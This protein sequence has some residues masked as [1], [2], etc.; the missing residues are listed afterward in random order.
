MRII[1]RGIGQGK[2]TELIQEY[3][4]GDGNKCIVVKNQFAAKTIKKRAQEMGVD[5][6]TV[7]VVDVYSIMDRKPNKYDALY[8]DNVDEILW[9]LFCVLPKAITLTGTVDR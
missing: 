5:P 8:V 2:T 1:I 7:N 6:D 9:S 4:R 3:V